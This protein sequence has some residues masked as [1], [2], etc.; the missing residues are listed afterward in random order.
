M[1]IRKQNQE[2]VKKVKF[3]KGFYILTFFLGMVLM[4]FEINIY[5]KTIIDSSILFPI[6]LVIGLVTFYFNKHHYNKTCLLTG[7]FF[8]LIQ[9]L[10]SWGFISCYAF[11]ATNYYL[12][13]KTTTEYKFLIKEKS[14]MPVDDDHH[15][16]ERKPLVRI[17]YFNFE[18][19]L[20]FYY[21]DKEKVDKADSVILSVRKGGLGFDI[22]DEYDVFN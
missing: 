9:N 20:V 6:I 12:A 11:M 19:E 3:W 8:P 17:D 13:D 10:F 1:T 14:S 7:N 18:K 4:I 22:I 21:V 15:W 5:R 16:S 2:T